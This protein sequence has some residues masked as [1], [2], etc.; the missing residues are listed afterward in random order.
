MLLKLLGLEKE[1]PELT[2]LERAE[3]YN[4]LRR[5]KLS[6]YLSPV[7]FDETRKIFYN[8]DDTYGI[9]FECCPVL[10][11]GYQ[12]LK[13]LEGLFRIGYPVGSVLQF[14]L[15]ADPDVSVYLDHYEKSK[16][17]AP[18]YIKKSYQSLR[19]HY[20]SKKYGNPPVRNY[21]LFFTIKM[22]AKNVSET[23]LK[24]IITSTK[25]T[26]HAANLLPEHV[27]VETYISFLRKVLNLRNFENPELWYPYSPIN[28]QVILS[29]TEINVRENT[30]EIT[31]SMPDGKKAKRFFRCV[32]VKNLPAEIDAFW[33]NRVTGS[34]DGVSGD[35][36]QINTPFWFTL[37]ILV[38]DMKTKLHGKANLV[39]GQQ[40]VGSLIP[41]LMR[42]KEEFFWAIDRID[43]GEKFFRIIP[44]VW[45]Y[46][47]DEEQTRTATYKVIRLWE[48]TGAVMQEDKTILTP[49]FIY[50][51]PF[52]FIIDH[53]TITLLD[54]DFI[55][56]NETLVALCPLQTDYCGTGE[57]VLMFLGRKGQ[58]IG[59]NLFSKG[60]SN[61]NFYI[62]APSGKGKSFLTNFIVTNYYGA[63]A[64]IRIVD[65]GGSYK[66]LVKMFNGKYLEFSPESD[67]CINP[68]S[69]IKDPVND[70][71]VIANIILQ[72]SISSTG[73]L[74]QGVNHESVVNLIGAAVRW[75]INRF[76][77]DACIDYVQQYLA[78]FPEYYDEKE[79]LCEGKEACV[80]DFRL[81]ATH[82]AFNLSKF[83]S[84][85]VYGRWFNGKSN[86]NIE[87]DDFVV[88]EL[89]HLK[90][91]EDLFKVVVLQVINMTTMDLYLSDRQNPRMVIF[92]EA[93]Q[94]LQDTEVFKKVIEE[95]YRRARKYGGSFGIITQ[96]I[97][98]LK[99]FGRVGD[100]INSS[101]EF[102]FFLESSDFE[103]AKDLKL[104]TFDDFTMNLLKSVKYNAPKYS[105]IFIH[106][107]TFGIGIVRLEVDPYSY[108]VYTSNPKEIAEIEQMVSQGMSYEQAIEEMIRKYRN[109]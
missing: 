3:L 40:A 46:S 33:A 17:Y 45:V 101:S 78:R 96:S 68:F 29:E 81:I 102:R 77:E 72:M 76:D 9:M 50:S 27:G 109:G 67:I 32:T 89:E 30:I 44:I 53:K 86:F 12:A 23:Q 43:K 95:G 97:L 100:V 35:I 65:I 57:P 48:S 31:G 107:D 94:F 99:H 71:P 8:Q 56:P 59:I 98:D 55:V 26:L 2:S 66:K 19:K 18:D 52:G 58:I 104:I 49:L 28:K 1:E 37:N 38:E 64:K 93:W 13:V 36:L 82:L 63:G 106:S 73:V 24:E 14:I 75:A 22:P 70:I 25:E 6:K 39:F 42:K 16:V 79:I 62:A 108:Y 51:L 103:R 61:Y 5:D 90:A 60:A 4:N 85:G 88:L 34:Y 84:S 47:E 15:Y 105:E 92:D 69:N 74:P 11:L 41:S 21:R 54:R 10:A 80:E 20:E 7:A 91:L 83:T 87:H